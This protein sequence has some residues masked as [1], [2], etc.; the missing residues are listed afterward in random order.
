MEE[1]VIPCAIPAPIIEPILS[2]AADAAAAAAAFSLIRHRRSTRPTTRGPAEATARFTVPT[3]R[4][5][6]RRLLRLKYAILLWTNWK[7]SF[8]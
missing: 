8:G 6:H 4:V 1:A 2:R 7:S 3:N 5:A